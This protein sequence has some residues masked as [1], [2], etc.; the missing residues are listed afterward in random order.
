[1]LSF[2]VWGWGGHIFFVNNLRQPGEYLGVG[3][4]LC[5]FL[6]GLLQD[7]KPQEVAMDV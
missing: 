6:F 1:M 2:C 7:T 5:L 3:V 4:G